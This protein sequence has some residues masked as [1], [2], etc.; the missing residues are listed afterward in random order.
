MSAMARLDYSL[1][2][3]LSPCSGGFHRSRRY[4]AGRYFLIGVA[5][6]VFIKGVPTV[7]FPSARPHNFKEPR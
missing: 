3:I 1:G 6:S 7:I 5:S 2:Y 4:V